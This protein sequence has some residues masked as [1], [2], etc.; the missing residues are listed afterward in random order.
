MRCRESLAHAFL[1][2][3]PQLFDVMYAP[4]VPSI[5][6]SVK[7]SIEFVDT[8]D[9]PELQQQLLLDAKTYNW[10]K[11]AL[12]KHPVRDSFPPFPAAEVPKKASKVK[13]P[14][15]QAPSS[16]PFA[17]AMSRMAQRQRT[18]EEV[19]RKDQVET[20]RPRLSASFLTYSPT[21]CLCSRTELWI[22][23][24]HGRLC[25]TIGRGSAS[26]WCFEREPVV[27]LRY[28]CGDSPQVLYNLSHQYGSPACDEDLEV[29]AD[30]LL[31]LLGDPSNPYLRQRNREFDESSDRSMAAMSMAD[32]SPMFSSGVQSAGQS[33]DGRAEGDASPL[34]DLEASTHEEAEPHYAAVNAL[35]RMASRQKGKARDVAV[36]GADAELDP[37][38]ANGECTHLAG[39]RSSHDDEGGLWSIGPPVSASMS[40]ALHFDLA[41]RAWDGRRPDT[42]G[43]V[44][45]RSDH[46][47]RRAEPVAE[48]VGPGRHTTAATGVGGHSDGAAYGRHRRHGR[49]TH[50]GAVA[51]ALAA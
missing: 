12:R 44:R 28:E 19:P 23:T 29:A 31:Q 51:L 16:L 3:A 21:S 14:N 7:S 36:G 32:G 1:M 9:L 37:D 17:T 41:Y 47:R 48:R 27:S 33:N 34:S 15:A 35:G 6:P 40:T 26:D 49:C 24:V 42:S 30:K 2:D 38:M 43:W 50:R 45:R 18:T 10:L 8:N 39:R 11:A 25:K 13:A 46:P 4:M 20:V 5:L 22:P